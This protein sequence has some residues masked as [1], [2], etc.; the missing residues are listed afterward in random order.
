M[1]TTPISIKKNKDHKDYVI[2]KVKCPHCNSIC[3][4]GTNVNIF[5]RGCD[6]CF[7]E[8]VVEF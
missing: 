5:T 8:Y 3:K 6:Y 4:H 1:K 7:K 2:V